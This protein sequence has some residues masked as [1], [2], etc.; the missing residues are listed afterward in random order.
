MNDALK[1]L[2]SFR[3]AYEGIKHALETQHNMRFHFCVSFFVLVLALFLGLSRT[4]MLFLLL[5]ITLVIV[6]ELMN[7]AIEKAVDLA[8]PELHPAAKIAKDSAAAA[9]LVSAV[10]AAVVGIAVFYKPLDELL[11]RVRHIIRPQPSFEWVAVFLTLVVLV[12]IVI[13]VRFLKQ[14]NRFHPSLWT[15]VAFSMATISAIFIPMTLVI[16]LVYLL[17]FMVMLVL[18][19]KTNRTALSLLCGA[20][21]G[22]V[23]TVSVFVLIQLSSGL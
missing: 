16:L 3:Y 6:S 12:L 7:T 10:F 11:H 2:R 21:V 15:A 20:A 9:V 4:D 1:I 8:M 19:D 23:M 18:Y 17:A 5:A 14:D 22:F 13:E